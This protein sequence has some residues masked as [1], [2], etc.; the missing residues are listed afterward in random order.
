VPLAFF[1]AASFRRGV[2]RA[3]KRAGGDGAPSTPGRLGY[4]AEEWLMDL[5]LFFQF[6]GL[7]SEGF[8]FFYR[9]PVIYEQM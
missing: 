6:S 8:P 2:P 5:G 7:C 4:L 9:S 3:V 1:P